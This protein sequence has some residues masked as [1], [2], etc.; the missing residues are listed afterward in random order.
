MAQVEPSNGEKYM[1]MFCGDNQTQELVKL[2]ARQAKC[3]SKKVSFSSYRNSPII[4]IISI[5]PISFQLLQNDL[6][7]FFLTNVFAEIIFIK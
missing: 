7:F 1:Y 5:F 3:F 6:W 2:D 4:H